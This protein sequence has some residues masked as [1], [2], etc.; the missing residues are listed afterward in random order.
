MQTIIRTVRTA[1]TVLRLHSKAAATTGGAAL[2]CVVLDAVWGSR[3][4]NWVVA[5]GMDDERAELLASLLVVSGAVFVGAMFSRQPDALRWGGLIAFLGIEVIP[6]LLGA[7][8]APSIAGLAA[9]PQLTGLLLQPLGMLLLS[10]VSTSLGIAAGGQVRLDTRRLTS[11]IRQRKWTWPLAPVVAAILVLAGAAAMT[12]LQDGPLTAIQSYDQ[13]PAPSSGSGSARSLASA[14]LLP[15]HLEA[16]SVGG[17]EVIVYVPGTY[18]VDEALRLPVVYFLH[19][20]PGGPEDWISGG[21][22]SEVLDQMIATSQL[23]PMLAVF[24]DGNGPQGQ[25]SEWGDSPS[26][27]VESWLV[28][29]V[30]P[31]I[32]GH[33]RTLGTP[34][35][36]VAG[37]SSGGFGALNLAIRNPDVF[38]WAASYSGYFL[39]RVGIYHAG[40]RANSPQ[41][42]APS[43]AISERMAIYLGWGSSDAGYAPATVQFAGELER[44]RWPHIDVDR[45]AGGHGWGAWRAEAVDSLRWLAQLWGPAPGT[46]SAG[47]IAERPSNHV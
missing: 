2:L 5:L 31:W 11:A 1:G 45:V 16:R 13:T 42:T 15:G 23:P 8:K 46:V 14:L 26:G 35:R 10:F 29:Q 40:W 30:V 7:A 37:L 21:Q 41:I 33:Y 9:A 3:L 22:M 44:L 17:R 24:P 34:F 27:D 20:T 18:A 4:T 32:D 28:R 6:F 25:D 38:R 47:S 43:L 19:G 12:A 39:A 36:G